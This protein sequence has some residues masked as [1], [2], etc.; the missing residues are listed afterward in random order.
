MVSRNK[1]VYRDKETNRLI[2]H[3]VAAQRDPSTW[4]EE[5]FTFSDLPDSNRPLNDSE[6]S[7]Y[8]VSEGGG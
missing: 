5:Q 6:G 3:K 2:P 1:T 7:T 4:I 8:A